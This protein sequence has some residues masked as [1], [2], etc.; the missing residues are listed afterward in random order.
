MMRHC[1]HLAV[2]VLFLALVSSPAAAVPYFSLDLA[3]PSLPLVPATN[4]DTFSFPGPIGG[5]PVVAAPAAAMGLMG[6]AI[7]ELNAMTT[8]G[9]LGLLHFS[10]DRA[11]VGVGVAREDD[12][13]AQLVGEVARRHGRLGDLR[14]RGEERDRTE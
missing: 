9:A 13:G 5:P 8:G 1:S 6:G 3:S 2:T 12:A 4:S 7:D 10:V 11:S 14:V